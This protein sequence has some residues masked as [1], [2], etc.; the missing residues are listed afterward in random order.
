MNCLVREASETVDI[1]ANRAT[2]KY[3]RTELL[4]RVFWMLLWPL[5]RMSPRPAFAWRRLLLQV[6]GAKIGR[7]VHVYSSATIYY[8]WMLRVGE[9]AAIGE[10]VL[11]YN[12]GLVTIG[13]RAT[14]SH[15]AHICAGTH[16]Y[17]DPSLPLLRPPVT[18]G[19]DTWICTD[20]FVGPGVTVGTG[21]VIGARAAVFKDVEPW[22][23]VGGNPARLIKQRILRGRA[24]CCP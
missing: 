5:F 17:S 24:Q 20:A 12:L 23:V 21:A 9:Q 16:D 7:H 2:Q 6:L 11:I 22:G 14:I 1:G 10:N 15:R 13:A 3:S 4:R 18:I 19:D 8:P